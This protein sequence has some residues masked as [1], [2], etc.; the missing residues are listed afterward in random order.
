MTENDISG[1]T[2]TVTAGSSGTGTKFQM[3]ED[4]WYPAVLTKIEKHES[5]DQKFGPQLNWTFE[6]IGEEFSYEYQ[7]KKSQST[8]RG[9]TSMLFS[10]NPKRPSKLFTWYCKLKGTVP[11]DGEKVTIGSLI[12]MKVAVMVKASP[13]KDKQGNPTTWY[14]VD[15]VRPV[16]ESV[17]NAKHSSESVAVKTP[18]PTATTV[19]NPNGVTDPSQIP[20]DII[21]ATPKAPTGDLYKDVF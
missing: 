11:G 4:D 5:T 17:T 1:M 16:A 3:N 8:V 15:K 10:S 12:G 21:S 19:K 6:L 20:S 7:E 14:N 13:G 9:S 2:F 18:S